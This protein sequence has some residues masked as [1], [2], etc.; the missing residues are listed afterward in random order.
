MP[1]V[2]KLN[3]P[4]MPGMYNAVVVQWMGITTRKSLSAIETF[5]EYLCRYNFKFIQTQ[6]EF[7]V[8]GDIQLEGCYCPPGT[9]LM[10]S[11]SNYCIPS[12][13]KNGQITALYIEGVG[14]YSIVL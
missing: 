10:S 4:V 11:S 12:C 3:Q 6:N 14:T 7:S 1:A 8:M 2:H 9:T 5:F 13:G